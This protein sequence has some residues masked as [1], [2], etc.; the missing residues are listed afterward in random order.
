MGADTPEKF[1]R[2]ASDEG[3]QA[4]EFVDG[5]LRKQG[6]AFHIKTLKDRKG[7]YGRYLVDIML[8]YDEDG[9]KLVTSRPLSE[10]LITKGIAEAYK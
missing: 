9:Q 3:Q 6:D 8:E 5:L 7:K 4:S 10:F 1:G 2:R